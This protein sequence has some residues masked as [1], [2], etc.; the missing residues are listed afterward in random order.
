MIKKLI[1][2]CFTSSSGAEH[3]VDEDDSRPVHIE[4]HDRG[5]EFFGNWIL[6]DIV[7]MEGNIDRA[8]VLN[9]EFRDKTTGE[10]DSAI[11]DS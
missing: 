10:L 6:P 11:G 7:A 4:W 5:G 9:L 8:G 2:S 1:E 3:V